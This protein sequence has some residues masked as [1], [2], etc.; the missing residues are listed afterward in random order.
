MPKQKK[1]HG[2]KTKKPITQLQAG[3]KLERV[4][5]TYKQYSLVEQ[6]SLPEETT[7]HE[8][9]RLKITRIPFEDGRIQLSIFH[10][11]RVPKFEE[12]CFLRT[13]LLPPNREAQLD[14]PPQIEIKQEAT[15]VHVTVAA[16]Q[17]VFYK[18]AS[19]ETVAETVSIYRTWAEAA[20]A[21][22]EYANALAN[23]EG[24]AV[25]VVDYENE[26]L[27]A[28]GEDVT[29]LNIQRVV[30]TTYERPAALENIGRDVDEQEAIPA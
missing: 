26:R 24:A 2:K 12:V 9:G 7:W 3:M 14:I 15:T 13:K 16:E 1:R 20:G 21:C 11:Y 28:D 6:G 27:L 25:F 10:P 29:N 8:Y 22:A 4:E 23:G 17:E 5:P 19:F 18:I 30:V